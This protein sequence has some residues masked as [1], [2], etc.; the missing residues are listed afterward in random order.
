MPC[1]NISLCRWPALAKRCD[2]LPVKQKQS[3]KCLTMEGHRNAEGQRICKREYPLFSGPFIFYDGFAHVS[4]HM[5]LWGSTTLRCLSAS[6]EDKLWYF[7]RE[8]Q[9][10]F[11][12]L[13]ADFLSQ[14]IIQRSDQRVRKVSYFACLWY[15]MSLRVFCGSSS[16]I[17]KRVT[18]LCL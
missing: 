8:T 2:S 17:T 15:P 6:P 10:L 11:S 12:L 5:G 4:C 13:P 1:S 3:N 14:W 9:D 18:F 16:E 7:L